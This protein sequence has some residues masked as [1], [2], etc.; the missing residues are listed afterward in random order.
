MINE[1]WEPLIIYFLYCLFYVLFKDEL[2]L[3]DGWTVHIRVP[4]SI[5]FLLYFRWLGGAK[6]VWR[7]S[8]NVL[9]YEHGFWKKFP[10]P[11]CVG[12]LW[13]VKEVFLHRY[14]IGWLPSLAIDTKDY[15]AFFTLI[16]KCCATFFFSFITYEH[17]SFSKGQALLLGAITTTFD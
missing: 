9:P 7:V 13:C 17:Y 4:Q 3:E 15:L 1:G 10:R 12:G 6:S 16:V 14:W 11:L 5:N 8:G 2:L